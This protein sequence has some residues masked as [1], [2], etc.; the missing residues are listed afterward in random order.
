MALVLRICNVPLERITRDYCESANRTSAEYRRSLLPPGLD[1]FSGAEAKTISQTFD[2]IDERFGGLERY[3][4]SI[5]VGP[6]WRHL[7]RH[8]LCKQ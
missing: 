5:G 1:S 7:I 4:D 2:I 8:K 3:L 6:E